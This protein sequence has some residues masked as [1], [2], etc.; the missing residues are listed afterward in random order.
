MLLGGIVKTSTLDYP[1]LLSAVIFTRGCN[2]HCPFCHNIDL[3]RLPR[4]QSDTRE[5]KET[6]EARKTKDTK[7]KREK[8]VQKAHAQIELDPKEPDHGPWPQVEEALAFL[9]KR[10]GL[11]DG[12]VVSGGE[13]TIQPDLPDFLAAIKALGYPIKLDTNGSNPE[14][15]E[16]LWHLGLVDYLAVDLK[17][18]PQNYSYFT[19]DPFISSKI[20]QTIDL[21]LSSGRNA[22]FRTTCLAPFIDRD[23]ISDLARLAAGP[24]PLFLQRYR[25]E[26][27]LNPSFMAPYPQPSQTDLEAFRLLASRYLSCYLR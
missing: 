24:I 15:I 13:P 23:I 8:R 10:R 2:F 3:V 14:V 21:V 26:R 22:E 4:N 1:S 9:A 6:R 18:L 5:P 12:V 7:D 19:N 20:S 27:V 25:P 16:N 17:C 11:L